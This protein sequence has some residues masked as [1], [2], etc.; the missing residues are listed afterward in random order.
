M[1]A[2]WVEAG[3]LVEGAPKLGSGCEAVGAG[4]P[5]A[6]P[7]GVGKLRAREGVAAVVTVVAGAADEV[8]KEKLPSPNEGVD[9]VGAAVL[10]AA[11]VGG[12][13]ENDGAVWVVGADGAELEVGKGNVTD[14]VAGVE[15]LGADVAEVG[16]EKGNDGADVVGRV[17]A[18]VVLVEGGAKAKPAVGCPVPGV[19][20]LPVAAPGAAAK[21]NVEELAV[22][23]G[24]DGVVAP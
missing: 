19:V 24:S 3:A 2:S 23:L 20:I 1:V 15:R 17:N 5:G 16:L 11:E 7:E 13:K 8:E 6:P 9:V 10:G 18:G 21:G 12:G 4:V 22:R 14:G